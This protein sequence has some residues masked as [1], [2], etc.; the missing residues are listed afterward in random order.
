MKALEAERAARKAAEKELD[1]L[2]KGPLSDADKA[3]EAARTEGRNEATA[4]ANSRLLAAEIK[5]AAAGKLADP[6]D[7]RLIDT[8]DFKPDENGNFDAKAITA[9]IEKLI[10]DKPHLGAG[11][12]TKPGPVNGGPQGGLPAITRDALKAMTAQQIAELDPKLVD[13]ALAAP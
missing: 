5:A 9:A 4:A 7:A 8:S 13:A 2:K 10:V 3:L 6:D 11:F 1:A 12:V